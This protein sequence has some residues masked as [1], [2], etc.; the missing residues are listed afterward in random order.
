MK[1]LISIVIAALMIFSMSTTI[2]AAGT[3][4]ETTLTT[5]IS[6]TGTSGSGGNATNDF[7]D[8]TVNSKQNTTYVGSDGSDYTITVP[9]SLTTG[10][11]GNINISGVWPT[12][13]K[14]TMTADTSVTLYDEDSQTYSEAIPVTINGV[15][16]N[17]IELEG[18]SES[19]F[20][21]T[22]SISV[23]SFAPV[24]G[25]WS[26]TFYYN[27]SYSP[28]S[29]TSS[30]DSSEP[31]GELIDVTIEG[32]PLTN[33]VT[34]QVASNTTWRAFVFTDNRFEIKEDNSGN[35]NNSYVTYSSGLYVVENSQGQHV[36][37]DDLITNTESYT[38]AQAE[39]S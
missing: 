13:S 38:F 18:N 30:G 32:Y 23:G 24:L 19:A 20:D 9:A 39:P 25:N 34:I 35:L 5:P 17:K 29:A 4:V 6:V 8:S 15:T 36:S 12:G 3:P 22:Y 27:V 28:A 16:A 33:D 21:K 7:T 26:G 11:T 2:F 37:P 31:S 14:L 10:G 1:K